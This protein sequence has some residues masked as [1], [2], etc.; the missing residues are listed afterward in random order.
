MPQDT[1]WLDNNGGYV[2]IPTDADSISPQV[3]QV[4]R[5]F[6]SDPRFREKEEKSS[7]D[8]L[9]LFYTLGILL[10]IWIIIRIR[11]GKSRSYVAFGSL[12]N[13]EAD[14]DIVENTG[15]PEERDYLVYEGGELNFTDPE[16]I[17]V[18]DKRSIYFSRLNETDKEKFIARLRKFMKLKTFFIH[19]KSG[20]KEMPILI[21]AAAIQLSFG[22]AK[23]LLPDFPHIHIFPREF[24]ST[25]PTIRFLEGNVS[26]NSINIS[27]KHFLEGYNNPS[28]GLNVG[29]HEM[30]H[31]YYYQNVETPDNKDHNFVHTFSRFNR[32]G[33]HSFQREQEPGNDLY[34]DYA[35]KNFQE[36]W[37]ESVEIYFEKPKMLQT[38]Y[39]ELYE[40]M[41]ALL[42]QDPASADIG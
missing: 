30:A 38:V 16:I 32:S 18:L 37:A 33:S 31:A 23:Y 9:P 26:N 8:W 13:N 39:P 42:N 6:S 14:Y 19:D 10:L 28:D 20:F 41:C 34:S 12:V 40:A 29:L 35:L 2:I 7:G 11:D 25:E 1:A 21:S 24:I 5:Q 3:K 27:W 36:F 15:P 22:L 4:L 17:T